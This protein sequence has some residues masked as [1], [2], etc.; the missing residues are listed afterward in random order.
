MKPLYAYQERAIK[1]AIE[2]HSNFESIDMGM[3]KTRIMIEVCK[4]LSLKAFVIA[5]LRVALRTWPSEIEKWNPDAAFQ[6]LHGNKKDTLY[7]SKDNVDFKIINFDGLKWFESMLARHGSN[8]LSNRVLIIDESSQ[9]KNSSSNRFKIL[10]RLAHFFDRRYCLSATPLPRNY[11]DLWSQY[12][13]LDNGRL[14]GMTKYKYQDAHF[15]AIRRTSNQ[16]GKPI[17][18]ID[19]EL[20]NGHDKIIQDIVKPITTRLDSKDYLSLPEVVYNDIP[21][22]LG[23][24]VLTVYNH[25]KNN[26]VFEADN[27]TWEASNAGV[28]AGK[29]R[30]I[31]Q[32]G[33]YTEVG[34]DLLHTK[35]MDA[36]Q[37]LVEEANGDPILCPIQFKFELTEIRKAF[38]YNVPAIV[39]GVPMK[40]QTTI[41]DLWDKGEIPLLLCHPAA[42]SHG[43]NLQQGGH[44]IAWYCLPWDLE[45]YYQLNGRLAR[46]GQT[47]PVIIY[48]LVANKTIDQRVVEVL[49]N[50]EATQSDFL[51]A[52]KSF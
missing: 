41:L 8:Y 27:N 42:L 47:K 46:L 24:D 14:L 48:H 50:K 43:L 45:Q 6:V 31:V 30:Q 5:P 11:L 34:V 40:Q 36:L 22:D 17:S 37:E 16:G 18:Y 13:I 52:I 25:F 32:G 38:K 9:I 28:L 49:S 44:I 21:I 10:R 15:R 33:I 3:G 20:K 23:R 2:R 7:H 19:F 35:K 39:G 1:E 29:L 26:Y 12:F 4:R 51:Q